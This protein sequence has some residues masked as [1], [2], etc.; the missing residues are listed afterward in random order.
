M[1]NV[2]LVA[3]ILGAVIPYFFF[4]QHFDA[5][6]YALTAFLAQIFAN[7]A[8]SGFSADLVISSFVFWLFMFRAGEGAPKPWPF[9][10]INL[11]IG[12]SCALPAYLYW[13][14]RDDQT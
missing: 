4:V 6:G 13:Q 10:V 11:L 5:Q 2:Y 7:P 3:A 1:K 8:A 14:M 9:V 12:L